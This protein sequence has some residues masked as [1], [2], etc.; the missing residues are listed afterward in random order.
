MIKHIIFDFDGVIVESNGIRL[1]GFLELFVAYGIG[2][3]DEYR[4][5]LENA[6]RKSR[7]VKIDYFFS[8]ILEKS[9]AKHQLMEFA[10]K[11]SGIVFGRVVKAENVKG[12][13][14]FL[15][16]NMNQFDFALVSS[17][18]QKELRQI[19]EEK[20]IA[21]FFKQILESPTTKEANLKNLLKDE[22]WDPKHAVFVGDTMNDYY[23]ANQNHICFIARDS[24]AEKWNNKLK[25]PIIG[26][27]EQLE[28]C[29]NLHFERTAS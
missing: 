17:S 22:N 28:N 2:M 13:L 3:L 11:Y 14:S 7:Y 20:K 19:C 12:I 21:H 1:E 8:H 16:T 26:N 18:D 4:L 23:S 27:I 24:G 6:S 25:F 10:E 9:L 5:Y 15:Q 29:L